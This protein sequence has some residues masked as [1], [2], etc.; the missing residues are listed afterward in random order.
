MRGLGYCGAPLFTCI[1]D[2]HRQKMRVRYGS[3]AATDAQRFSVIRCSANG[4]AHARLETHF[5]VRNDLFRRTHADEQLLGV[6]S[7]LEEGPGRLAHPF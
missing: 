1:T 7:Q 3:I 6:H 2:F 4:L 5:T